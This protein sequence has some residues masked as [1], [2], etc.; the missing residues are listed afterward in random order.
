M[1]VR[2]ITKTS[3]CLSWEKPRDLGGVEPEDILYA[4]EKCEVKRGNW[5]PVASNLKGTELD[6]SKLVEGG[7]YKF[8]V[9][10]ENK[11]GVS[12]P[13]ESRVVTPSAQFGVPDA[14]GKIEAIDAGFDFIEIG[15]EKPVRDGGS[16][17]QGYVVEQKE[18]PAGK[19]L[20]LTIGQLAHERRYKS[21]KVEA[22]KNYLFRIRA[23]NE[24]GEGDTNVSDKPITAKPLKG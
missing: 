10:A 15:W 4:V 19:W 16:K 1:D 7:N 8:R 2:D 11:Y 13:L 14:P 17:I 24:A 6:V 5:M 23:V 3:C 20:K 18:V 9:T 22:R 21:K 12:D